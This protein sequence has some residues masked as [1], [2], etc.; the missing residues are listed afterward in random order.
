LPHGSRWRAVHAEYESS[1]F[2]LSFIKDESS[3][4]DHDQP[5]TSSGGGVTDLQESEVTDL[6]ESRVSDLHKS[7]VTARL[8]AGKLE[9]AQPGSSPTDSEDPE[10][11]LGSH[12]S[13]STFPDRYR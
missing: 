7:G 3:E 5:S 13:T 8:G 10:Q 1:A 9:E 2:L 11:K 12:A 6:E 4:N